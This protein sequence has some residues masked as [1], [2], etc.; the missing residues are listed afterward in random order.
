[1]PP[2]LRRQ[3]RPEHSVYDAGLTYVRLDLRSA[4]YHAWIYYPRTESFGDPDGRTPHWLVI[5]ESP[6]RLY[7]QAD[8]SL[9]RLAAERYTP[10]LVVPGTRTLDTAAVYGLGHAEEV[11]APAFE[12]GA[13]RPIDT[14]IAPAQSSFAMTSTRFVTVALPQAFIAVSV[15]EYAPVAG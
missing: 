10:V 6:L 15:T 13:L 14:G 7:A 12:R 2:L 5:S 3:L 8:P 11:V 9:E 1:M 4:D